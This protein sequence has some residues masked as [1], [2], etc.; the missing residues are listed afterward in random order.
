LAVGQNYQGGNDAGGE[1][2]RRAARGD[3]LD[4]NASFSGTH[5][6][7][8]LTAAGKF[9]ANDPVKALAAWKA[10]PEGERKPGAVSI[11]EG[12]PFDPK[13][14]QPTP[15][16]NGLILRLFY[17]H[18]ARTSGGDLRLAVQDDFT[19]G[20]KR[21]N[22]DAQP[23]YLWLTEAEW[24]SL[25]P[26]AP[27][28][29]D[30][31]RVADAIADRICLQYLHP[32]LSFCACS[33]WSKDHRRGQE[34]HLIVDDVS[35]RSIRLRLEGFARLGAAFESAKA[36]DL[37]G[38]FGYEPQLIGFVEYDRQAKCITRF[39]FVALGDVYGYPNTDDLAWRPSWRAGRQPLGVAFEL[40]SGNAAGDRVP[41]RVVP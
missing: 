8:C 27:K 17:R 3:R 34:L 41:A 39:E 13:K 18:L 19:Y 35:D 10:L 9:L 15:P 28:K 31:G 29:G 1:F 20:N 25:I 22:L 26:A 12:G 4:G 33:G 40:I 16:P 11:D 7:A 21:V 36:S 38:P 37:K 14:R 30:R 2:I 24:K 5:G 23:N 6:Y 32:V